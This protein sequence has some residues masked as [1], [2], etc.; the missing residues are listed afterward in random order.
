M[1]GLSVMGKDKNGVFPL[2]G[3]V[4]NVRKATAKQYKENTEIQNIKKILGLRDNEIYENVTKLRYG[5][6][7]IMADQDHDGSHIKGLGLGSIE[8]E[9]DHQGCF[10]DYE[11]YIKDF[12]WRDEDDDNAIEEDGSDFDRKEKCIRYLDFINKDFKAYGIVTLQRSIPSMVDGLK[13]GQRKILH[14]AFTKP[15]IKTTTK[16]EIFAAY[17]L[18]T[19]AYDN[20]IKNVVSSIMFMCRKYVGSNNINLLEPLGNFGTRNEKMNPAQGRYYE[21][22]L[23]GVTIE[24][25]WF[26]PIIPMVLVNGSDGVAVGWSSHIPNYNPR[27]I[28]ENLRLL[29]EGKVMV[30]MMIPWYKD[31]KGDVIPKDATSYTI[32]GTVIED[33]NSVTITDIPI[34]RKEEYLEQKLKKALKS[35][36]I[37]AYED[38]DD[39]TNGQ[40]KKYDRPEQIVKDFYE[41]RLSIYKKRIIVVLRKLKKDSLILENQVK[42]ISEC[43]KHNIKFPED[44]YQRKETKKEEEVAVG[45]EKL[46]GNASKMVKEYDYLLLDTPIL[47]MESKDLKE[48]ETK[49]DLKKQEFELLLNNHD[50]KSLWIKDL[51]ELDKQLASGSYGYY[52][53][54]RTSEQ[55]EFRGGRCYHDTSPGILNPII[56]QSLPSFTPPQQ[57]TS[58]PPPTTEATNPQSTLPDFASVFQFNK[59]SYSWK[60][61]LEHLENVIHELPFEI[62]H[63]KDRKMVKE[64]LEDA[65]LA[66]ESSQPQSSYEDAATLTEFEL[67]KILIDKMDK[68]ESY[69]TAP[70]HR[71]FYKGLI[72]SYDLDK[73]LFSTY[74]KVYSLKRSRKD[75]DKDEDPSAGEED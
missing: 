57:S 8:D 27:D 18:E 13:N 22:Q 31:F 60:R 12:V 68:S 69:L 10:V 70:E 49:L 73:S 3:K 65:V 41:L 42:Y 62:T 56:P 6:L 21:T 9:E 33:E 15:I 75:K 48:L 61:S 74:G 47:L 37:E 1:Y 51:N 5:H 26:I 52:P 66:K 54:A 34:R 35:G 20:V 23:S 71:E 16:I 7:M 59:R 19:M 72:K 50:L 30:D 11:K 28:I 43:W 24:P 40:L 46:Q 44:K 67:K 2:Q 32:Q 14:A 38:C 64:S 45:E 17:V 39:D 29:L 55:K 4:L 36:D 63:C 53:E 25:Q 58:T